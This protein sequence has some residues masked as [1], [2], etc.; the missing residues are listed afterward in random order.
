MI[1]VTLK[2]AKNMKFLNL[3]RYIQ[4]DCRIFVAKW[5]FTLMKA[6]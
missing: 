1:K 6:Q 2:M 3:L 5:K 4:A